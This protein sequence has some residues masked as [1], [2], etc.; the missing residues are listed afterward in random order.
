VAAAAA[1][2]AVAAVAHFYHPL[3]IPEELSSA[4]SAVTEPQSAAWAAVPGIVCRVCCVCLSLSVCVYTVELSAYTCMPY[5]CVEF[6]R[7]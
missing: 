3:V 2:G 6:F 7:L 5:M 1:L 4:V